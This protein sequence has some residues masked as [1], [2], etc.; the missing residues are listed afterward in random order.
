MRQR[1]KLCKALTELL[2][3]AENS[4]RP[5]AAPLSSWSR[6]GSNRQPPP[7]KSGALP[8]ELRPQRSEPGH[9][10]LAPAGASGSA[11]APEPPD[12][13]RQHGSDHD[14]LQSDARIARSR[15]QVHRH[16]GRHCD[17]PA[18]P[19]ADR[20]GP[21]RFELVTSSLSGTR[22]NQLSYEPFMSRSNH[23][24]VGWTAGPGT[25]VRRDG[26]P[27]HVACP[28]GGSPRFRRGT[29]NLPHPRRVSSS[30]AGEIGQR[31]DPPLPTVMFAASSVQ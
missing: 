17:L 28:A 22:S 27:R 9:A 8:T 24:P 1:A 7:C 23:P 29:P 20:M 31:G 25:A 10:R 30:P 3:P 19:R 2:S 13:Q 16:Q 18:R 5:R 12:Q 15:Q 6:P 26:E 4:R 11:A 14:D 21:T